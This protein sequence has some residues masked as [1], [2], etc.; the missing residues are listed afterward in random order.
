MSAHEQE[1]ARFCERCGHHK[2]ICTCA[3]SGRELGASAGSTLMDD[4]LGA[5]DE[6]DKILA[7]LLA[8]V[9]TAQDNPDRCMADVCN[10]NF[11]AHNLPLTAVMTGSEY[12]RIK[13]IN[14]SND[15]LCHGAQ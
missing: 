13:I 4:Y 15:K 9:N 2:I 6:R 12:N 7:V 1:E 11:I 10:D 5:V 14:T 8:I 3:E